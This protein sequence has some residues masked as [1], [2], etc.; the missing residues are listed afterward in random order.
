MT[1]ALLRTFEEGVL[2]LTLN[3]PEMRNP[4]SDKAVLDALCKAVEEAASILKPFAQGIDVLGLFK[5]FGKVFSSKESSKKDSTR[6]Q[7]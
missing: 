4:V 3:R 2:T 1:D 5:G 7:D 6:D